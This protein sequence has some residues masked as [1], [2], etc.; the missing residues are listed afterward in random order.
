MWDISCWENNESH[1]WKSWKIANIPLELEEEWN[2]LKYWLQGKSPLKK[3]KKDKRVWGPFSGPYTIAIGYHY[4]A[5]VPHI[6][7]DPAIWK[8]IWSSKSILKIDIYVWTM[9][10]RGILTSENL[11]RRAWE[12]P[13]RCPLCYQEE[14]TT[15]HLLLSCIYSKEVWKLTLGLHPKTLVLTQE[16]ITMLQNWNSLCPF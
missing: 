9:T 15:D 12:G 8:V 16:V 10:H 4:I 2:M 11:R 6:P 1:S 3:R 7:P 5:I 14:E 13:S